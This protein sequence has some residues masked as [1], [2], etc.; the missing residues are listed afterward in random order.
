LGGDAFPFSEGSEN[1]RS[2]L[3]VLRSGVA[4][5]RRM[6]SSA[7]TIRSIVSFGLDALGSTIQH[8]SAFS[9]PST[10]G[11]VYVPGD[12]PDGVF[13]DWVGQLRYFYRF[14]AT[15]IEVDLRGDVQLSDR[16]L[17]TLEQFVVGGPGSV[18]GYRTNALAGDGG[19]SSGLEVRLPLVSTATGRN[20]VSLLPF[21][22]VGRIWNHDRATPGKRTLSSLGAGVEWAPH[23]AL[24][25]R[26]DA[27]GALRDVSPKNDLQDY[28]V[29]FRVTWRPR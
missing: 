23:S 29:T 8:G 28:G 5:T 16:P 15:G 18:R 1:G 4:W 17:M 22:D 2:E 27:A 9:V 21:A 10:G 13:F 7:L 20:I 3:S 6:S 11:V 12:P 14:E 25:F 19:F 24:T 26:V